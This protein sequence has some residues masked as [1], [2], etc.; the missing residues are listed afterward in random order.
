MIALSPMP[1]GSGGWMG[2]RCVRADARGKTLHGDR[3]FHVC[4][5][6]HNSSVHGTLAE[7][8]DDH[9]LVAAC[10]SIQLVLHSA[11]TRPANRG[12]PGRPN[13]TLQIAPLPPGRLQSCTTG[14]LSVS[15]P[16][17]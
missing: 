8:S 17:A 1:R 12:T 4:A 14:G 10:S 11:Q 5:T 16:R 15:G 3:G 7:C 9:P 13:F 6:R 2:A